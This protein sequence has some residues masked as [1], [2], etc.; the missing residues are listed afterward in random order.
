MDDEGDP[1]ITAIDVPS[2]SLVERKIKQIDETIM[3]LRIFLVPVELIYRFQLMKKNMMSTVDIDRSLLYELKS[4]V[5]EA[6]EELAETLLISIENE[7]FW[8]EVS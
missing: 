1:E 7:D 5:R 3:I 2:F 4:G 8:T 6:E